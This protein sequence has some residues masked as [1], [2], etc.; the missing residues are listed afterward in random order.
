MPVTIEVFGPAAL[1]TMR[2]PDKRNALGPADAAELAAAL[3]EG[4]ARAKAGLILTG[5]GAFCAGGDLQEFSMLSQTLTVAEI[6]ERIYSDIH[7]VL[8]ALHDCPVPCITA[9]DGPAIGLGFDY[10]I[11][12]DMCVVGIGGWL[13]QG[14]ARVGLIHGAGGSGFLTRRAPGSIWK[15]IAEQP[16]LDGPA[17]Q[18]LGIAE[19][20]AQGAVSAAMARIERLASLSRQALQAYTELE[21]RERWPDEAYFER[22]SRLQ[23]EFIGSDEFRAHARRILAQRH[24]QG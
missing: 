6:R 3:S 5:E 10:A 20:A 23:A 15:L 16:R 11:A 2:W 19:A 24:G 21:R 1:V 18:E 4:A 8:R 9:I 13:Q 17:A 14:W 7:A 12:A 22:C